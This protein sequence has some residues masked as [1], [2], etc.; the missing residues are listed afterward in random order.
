MKNLKIYIIFGIVLAFIFGCSNLLKPSKQIKSNISTESVSNQPKDD[1]VRYAQ[2]ADLS[3]EKRYQFFQERRAKKSLQSKDANLKPRYPEKAWDWFYSRRINFQTKMIPIDYREKAIEHSKSKCAAKEGRDVISSWTAV[4]PFPPRGRL[5]DICVHP[6]DDNIIYV[7]SASGGVWKTTDQGQNWT[8]LTDNKIPT[9]GIGSLIMDPADPNTL[10]A[11]LG[12]GLYGILYDPLGSGIYKTTDGGTTWNIVP[13]SANN[14][15]QVTV[16][17]RFGETSQIIYAACI[18]AR[19][20]QNSYD[21][22]GFFKSTDGGQ[23]FNLKHNARCWSISINPTN[24]QNL[25]ITADEGQNG[26]KFYY[27][28]NGGENLTASTIPNIANTRRAELARSSTNPQVLYALVSKVDSSLAGIWKSTDGGINW[29]ET[30]LNG[31][32]INDA[33]EK[34]GQMNYNN[35]I[36]VA[37]N[38]A[39]TVYI[40]TNLR[41]YKTTDGASNWN[42]L[43]YWWTPNNFS[44]PYVHADHHF[45]TFGKDPNTVFYATDGGFHV[46]KDGGVT[47]EERNNNLLCTQIYRNSNGLVVENQNVIGCQDNSAYVQKEDGSWA[48]IP[49][50][51]DGFENI[52]DKNDNNYVYITGYYGNQVLFS[53]KK[54]INSDVWYY[55]R[56]RD[57]NNGIPKDE[58]GAW[59][60]PLIYDP[61][62]PADL[63]LGLV[64]LYKTT[65]TYKPPDQNPVQPVWQ[66]LITGQDSSYQ[67]EIVRLTYGPTDRKIFYFMSRF[68]QQQ[69][70]GIGLVRY[71]IDGTGSVNI[72]T[73][74]QGFINEIACDPNN[75]NYVWL[76]YSDIGSYPQEVSRIYKSQDLGATWIDKTSN[77]PK[78]LPVNAIFIDPNNSNTIII[79]TDIGVYRSDNDGGTWYYF[80]TG[81]PNTV[82]TDIAYFPQTRKIRAATYGRGLWET[83]IDGAGGKPDIRI[84][85]NTIN[86]K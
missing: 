21:G 69:G 61:V 11:G 35:C 71:N 45:I 52:V 66:K 23:T 22:M 44:L 60:V 53:H 6:Q 4:G 58:Q 55:L 86:F 17:I 73:P 29:S 12:E 15:L 36:A 72:Q 57:G 2:K 59:V 63:Y 5:K 39:N 34:P 18:G 65:M 50:F 76:G 49:W 79:G 56:D 62:N 14:K 42:S 70:W 30:A 84:V 8:C 1:E 80:S 48:Y 81:L 26:A 43:C 83:N 77:L 3:P 46:S 64:N 37:P 33:N 38:D 25:V 40:G 78:N 24:K 41:G 19:N 74:R 20:S 28:T 16:D 82:V 68:S 27:S 7:G 54:G 9:L 75:N 32:P 51:G 13:G 47:W 67:M 85:P 10:Y 31:I